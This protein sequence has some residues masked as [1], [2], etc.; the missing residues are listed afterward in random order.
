MEWI[1][2]NKSMNTLTTAPQSAQFCLLFSDIFGK[3]SDHLKVNTENFVNRILLF[4]GKCDWIMKMTK[5]RMQKLLAIFR[6]LV[7]NKRKPDNNI[8]W[9]NRQ[10]ENLT[11]HI[12]TSMN[13]STYFALIPL[14][15]QVVVIYCKDWI[16]YSRAFIM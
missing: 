5:V 14:G 16:S 8:L 15:T 11:E 7:W 1:N 2:S 10:T 3:N 12:Y 13:H 9:K 4:H 6:F